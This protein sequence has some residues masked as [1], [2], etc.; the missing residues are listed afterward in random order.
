MPTA[1]H[2]LADAFMCVSNLH[3]EQHDDHVKRIALFSM[4]AIEAAN[5]TPI[6][7]T[8]AELGNIHIR[9]GFH[10][11]PVVANVVGS[12]NPRYCL[13]QCS[14]PLQPLR[15]STH[16]SRSAVGDTVNVSSRMESN[17]EKDRIHLS[18]TSTKLLRKQAPEL[19]LQSR[20]LTHIKGSIGR[21][22]YKG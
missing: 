5:A 15:H 22:L 2:S 6:S 9:V 10:T 1:T 7:M 16:Y 18:D 4:D 17:S 20:G 19:R 8:D 14:L 11:G 13:C 12:K 21:G 3:K